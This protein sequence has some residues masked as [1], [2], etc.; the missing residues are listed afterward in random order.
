M[1]I[2]HHRLKPLLRGLV[3]AGLAGVFCQTVPAGAALVTI[4]NWG[5]EVSSADESYVSFSEDGFPSIRIPLDGS[6][7]EGTVG[8]DVFG[9]AWI[10]ASEG[11]ESLRIDLSVVP[12][13]VGIH[14]SADPN[15]ES[16]QPEQSTVSV[17]GDAV[18]NAATAI[19]GSQEIMFLAGSEASSHVRIQ[20]AL[21]MAEGAMSLSA[22]EV[23]YVGDG[24]LGRLATMASDFESKL[25]VGEG[26]NGGSA[27]L[28]IRE[29]NLTHATVRI[30]G[31]E[32]ANA[33]RQHPEQAAAG[34]WRLGSALLV[35]ALTNVVEGDYD[36]LGRSS[37]SVA[38]NGTLAIG[39]QLDR[40]NAVLDETIRGSIYGFDDLSEAEQVRARLAHILADAD[41]LTDSPGRATLITAA[42]LPFD[43]VPDTVTIT[44]GAVADAPADGGIYLGDDARW[45]IYYGEESSPG[46][47]DRDSGASAMIAHAGKDSQLIIYG[48]DGEAA[49]PDLTLLDFA[50]ENVFSLNGVRTQVVDGKLQ[51]LWCWQMPGLQSSSVVKHVEQSWKWGTSEV[52]PG[53]SFIVDSFDSDRVGTHAYAGVIDSSLFLPA[54]SG[55][56]TAVERIDR[57]V[58][59]GLLSH[60]YE[61]FAGKRHWWVQGESARYESPRLF[62]VGASR[63]GF[64][65]DGYYATLG[66]D[67]GLSSRWVGTL[68]VSFSSIDVQSRGLASGIASEA[69]GASVL[70]SAARFFDR[71]AIKFALSYTRSE[72]TSRNAVNGHVLESEPVVEIMS[73][74]ARWEGRFGDEYYVAPL[75]QAGFHYADFRDGAITDHN[76]YVHGKGFAADA[77][78]RCW[79]TFMAGARA[80]LSLEV[81][82]YQVRPQLA[83]AAMS[84]VGERDWKVSTA[85]FDGSAASEGVFES[86]RSFSWRAEGALEIASS[87]S[88]PRMEG[89]IF[90]IGAKDTGFTDPYAWSLSVNAA[91]ES[92]GDSEKSTMLGLQ[93]RQLF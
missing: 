45:V 35:G 59:N 89:G 77:S 10:G 3:A 44:V 29:L 75:L 65:A 68:A 69:S 50:P 79:G 42:G 66:F 16:G 73:A 47:A 57:D 34:Q 92:A 53:Y 18:I 46:T 83:L 5:G 26:D 27:V 60:D 23:T 80:G 87:G 54:S 6:L 84:A 40:P 14:L 1:P 61:L 63:W 43:A 85:L 74:A 76:E 56:M 7:K 52:R 70:A 32:G 19:R 93:F 38:G 78:D 21:D 33:F 30:N 9:P 11:R 28:R 64:E 36:A 8:V 88:R 13:S 12:N 72:L 90:G 2:D 82:G 62:K 31:D 4:Q 25:S 81:L 67:L 51:R 22:A 71:S 24:K 20:G 55:A 17:Y 49:L 48:W 37:I 58:L 86:A 41:V 91:Y 39:T 15:P